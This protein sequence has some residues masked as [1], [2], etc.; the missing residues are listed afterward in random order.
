MGEA[1]DTKDRKIKQIFETMEYGDYKESTSEV[2]EWLTGKDKCIFAYIDKKDKLPNGEPLSIKDANNENFL[3]TVYVPEAAVVDIILN[4][5]GETKS[6]WAEVA[7]TKRADIIY[8]LGAEIKKKENLLVQLEIAVR[9]I[10]KKDTKNTA[11]PLLTNYLQY[12][13]SFSVKH[14][15][16]NPSWKPDGLVVGILSDENPLS[17]VA[18]ILGPAL[19][20]GYNVVLQTGPLLSV[21][22]T[23][24]IDIAV[25]TGIPEGTIK[26]IPGNVKHD[27]F[28]THPKVSVVA[29]FDDLYKENYLVANNLNKKLLHF[30]SSGIPMI[31]FDNCDLDS[32][33]QSVINSAWGYKGMVPWSV[34][35]IFIQENVFESFTEK[36]KQRVG[37]LRIGKSDEKNVDVTYPDKSV[38]EKIADLAEKARNEGVEVYQLNGDSVFPVL[39]IGGNVFH[40]NVIQEDVI[41]VPVVTLTAFRTINEAVALSNNTRQG[42]AASV[43]TENTSLA[44]EIMGKLK[45]SNVW[46]NCHG[47][48][49]AEA[50]MSPYKTSGNA[51]FGGNE[52]FYEYVRVKIL[53]HESIL[54]V[55]NAEAMEKA[56]S[57]AKKGQAMWVKLGEFARKKTLQAIAQIL[58]TKKNNWGL[59]EPWLNEWITLIHDYTADHSGKNFAESDGFNVVSLREPRGV[60]AVETPD[61]MD[62]HNKRLIIAAL[63][64]GNSVIVL[65]DVKETTDFYLYVSGL[66]P[67]GIL[68]VTPHCQESRK[69]AALHKELNVYVG[70]KNNNVFRSLPLKISCKFQVANHENWSEVRN[71]VTLVKNV[72]FSKGQS[73]M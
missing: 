11:L 34:R 6:T 17:S 27:I 24:L 22:V 21:T 53:K 35:N 16:D 1:G 65:N 44:N 10:L 73:F 26:L 66:L 48:F 63:A 4:K 39:L 12:C 50:S 62:G 15:S 7:P 37:Q 28:F 40:N 13:S 43:W 45:V 3:C 46:I 70:E 19:A 41:N 60:I 57:E 20:A 68:L 72:W 69:V 52:G 38:L 58:E 33:C 25:Q 23:A 71:K 67:K 5:L 51:F 54:Q 47:L 14:N 56:I 36:L 31:V 30:Y 61:Q 2:T 32:A 9:G 42:L 49:S 18:H 29:I 59:S 8:K 64:E 55:C